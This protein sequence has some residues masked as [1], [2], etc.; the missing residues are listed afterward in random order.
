MGIWTIY[1]ANGVAKVQVKELELHDEWMA[2]CFLTVTVKH[3]E[4]IDFEVGDYLDY[5]GERYTIN[6]DPTVL[7]K[8]RRGTYGEGFTYDN[9][10]FVAVQDELVRCDF[11]DIVLQDN[12]IHYTALPTFPFYCETVDDLL[13]RIQAN[14]EELYPGMWTIISPDRSRDAQRGLCVDRQQEF[15]N[16]YEQ[17]IGSG[18]EFNYEKKGV[19]IT[20]DNVNCWEA[21]KHAH[22]DFDL[23]FIIRG[24]T[25]IV[26]TAG[27]I[28]PR[29]FKYGRGKG[30]YEIERISDSEQKIITRLRG[31][32]AETNLPNRYYATIGQR[33]YADVESDVESDVEKGTEQNPYAGMYLN[34][35]YSAS[36]FR[37]SADFAYDEGTVVSNHGYAVRIAMDG[38]ELMANVQRWPDTESRIRLYVETKGEGDNDPSDEPDPEKV[39]AFMNAVNT[40]KRIY[41][42][43]GVNKAA[44]PE[45]RMITET[46]TGVTLPDNMAVNRLMLPGFPTK[47]LQQWVEEHMSDEK[48]AAAVE[49]GFT[50]ST[51]PLRP[52]IESPNKEFIGLRPGSIY[53]DGTDSEHDDIHP[54]IEGMT[55]QGRAAD[56]IQNNTNIEDNGVL[57]EN[58]EASEELV[59]LI[60]PKDGI[61]DLPGLIENDSAIEM[62]DGMC[63]ARKLT[64]ESVKVDESGNNWICTCKRAYD[65]V[66]K[67][68]FP[69]KDFQIHAGD[70]FVLTGIELP[71]SYI[72]AASER[73]F[74]ATL[75]ALA[76]NH[77]PRYTFQ[78]RIDELWMQRQHD[79]AEASG[80]ATR[81]LHDT[82]KAG[83]IF[84]FED[85]DLGIDAGIIIDILTIKE[86]GQVPTYEV[87][88]RD[89][90]QVSV[91]DKR[92]D[93]VTT[94]ISAGVNGGSGVGTTSKQT[95][96]QIENEGSKLFLSKIED[97]EAQGLIGFLKGAWFGVK[98]W[99]I[100]AT[101]NANLNDI[102]ANG[103]LTANN[104]RSTQYTGDS[105]F[106]TGY[107][108]EFL[109]GKSKLVI[110]NIVCRGKFVVNEIEDRIWTYAGGNLIFSAAGST[111][112]Y[113]E[114]LD[115]QGNALGYTYINSPWLLRKIPLLAGIIAWSKRRQI[116]RKLTDEEKQQ[117]AIFRCYETSDDGTMQTR[118]WWH[119]DDLAYCQTLNR[120]KDKT[121]TSGGYSGS[122]SNTVYWRRVVNIGSKKIPLINDEKIY[123]Y[124]DLSFSDCDEGSDWPAAGD[125]IVQRGNKTDK[126]RQGFTTIEVTGE[127]RGIRVWDEC[128]DYS[129]L[130]TAKAFLGYDSKAERGMLEVFG[131]AY[132]GEMGTGNDPHDG[133]TYVRYNSK[134]R[135]LDIKAKISA[136]STVDGKALQSYINGLITDITDDIQNEVDQKAETWYQPT[137]P[138]TVAR[139][140]GWLGEPNSEHKGDLWH[141]TTDNKDFYYNGSGWSEQ[142]V[143]DVVYDT[144]DGKAA[145]YVTWN[146]WGNNLQVKDLFI[147][148]ADT[149]QGGKTY[150]KN[151]V[152][153]CTA[154]SP[155]TF[156]EV[157]YTN[158]AAFLDWKA[159][160]YVNDLTGLQDDIDDAASD[161]ATAKAKAEAL[162]YIKGALAGDTVSEG[163]LLLTSLIALR[164]K[165][166][167]SYT[168]YG[169]IN[170]VYESGN[171]IA[172]WFGGGM[173]A[174][175]PIVF[176]MDGHGHLAGG[177]IT[178]DTSGNASFEGHIEA[179]SG[180]IGG[181]AIYDNYVGTA[182]VKIYSD[183]R[184]VVAK[185]NDTYVDNIGGAM[186]LDGGCYLRGYNSN[187]GLHVFDETNKVEIK[188]TGTNVS[189]NSY[190]QSTPD[191]IKVKGNSLEYSYN[192][193]DWFKFG[194][195][196]SRTL[197][198]GTITLK[199]VDETIFATGN[200][201]LPDGGSNNVGLH[202]TIIRTGVSSVRVTGK[203]NGTSSSNWLDI[204]NQ[205]E[206]HEL[207]WTGSVWAAGYM[208]QP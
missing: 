170:G 43:E 107:L 59:E 125:V 20:V 175:A 57:A 174:N 89:E 12:N 81:S 153:R 147:P 71:D 131:D 140:N 69:Y 142:F 52:Y 51:D 70:H 45:D 42:I 182:Y 73:L 130:E 109:R 168:T 154:V 116:Q 9:I 86:G 196:P 145:V 11:C 91:I 121:V 102:T 82:L 112:F 13:D 199:G 49:A 25:V 1:G 41:F 19:A 79:T 134:T 26:G 126:E 61:D 56:E 104:V 31:Y 201:T 113:V 8:A 127:K 65:D 133:G 38:I 128:K 198:S 77:A 74:Y 202:L 5:R 149:S 7:K 177:N 22:D 192:G 84:A 80:G 162:D 68:Y 132:I 64:I 50:F 32:G 98:Q 188:S 206:I 185:H 178:W 85:E 17:Y 184:V 54:T 94:L 29:T 15:I 6:Y 179:D 136:E 83:D 2:E 150:K 93:K 101:G 103:Q 106:D 146:A 27:L 200:L 135:T 203:I 76:D 21:L 33:P 105:M 88:L 92:F 169:G 186:L 55:W 58:H 155:L 117:V 160:Q 194:R 152:Y 23:N 34:V 67:L 97:D 115:A 39:K 99:I 111:I 166:G 139:P 159:G 138:A 62:K 120:V 173:T 119:V 14:M 47:S 66:L 141:R 122:L 124:V 90:K 114:Y 95:S 118:N 207:Y 208:S 3:H 96:S 183:G 18:T 110:D 180:N 48:V 167:S 144:I 46:T 4:P 189:D 163:G 151:K 171:S 36:M 30:L 53:F 16:A 137:D 197:S 165:V 40:G 191:G 63:G 123:D 87:T 205:Y 72:T 176:Y 204:N 190:V 44:W 158:D 35:N 28:T 187:S 181:L 148:A 143:P 10:K 100:D 60:I 37:M 164:K 129:K 75:A 108:L 156:E 172:A 195:K 161:A 193:T 24:R 157:D 78:P